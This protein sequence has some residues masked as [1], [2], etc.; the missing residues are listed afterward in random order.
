M[1]ELK[2]RNSKAEETIDKMQKKFEC[3]T[4]NKKFDKVKKIGEQNQ[5]SIII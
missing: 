4:D 3:I 5:S 1:I 2:L